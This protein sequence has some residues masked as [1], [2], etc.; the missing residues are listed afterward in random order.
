MNS[1]QLGGIIRAVLMAFSGFALEHG[2]TTDQWLA[3]TGGAV[4]IATVGWSIY[5]NST[6]KM[7]QTVAEKP[8]VAKVV[9]KEPG[10]AIS[11][12]SDKVVAR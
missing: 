9:T 4:A 2:V 1:D 3:I 11:I 6:T 12:P 7:I 8:E 5:S 10:F